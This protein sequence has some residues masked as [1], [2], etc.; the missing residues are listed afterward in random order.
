MAT[1]P[2]SKTR[3]STKLN[4]RAPKVRRSPIKVPKIE[5]S[6]V[7][8]EGAGPLGFARLTREGPTL[9]ERVSKTKTGLNFSTGKYPQIR[10]R[11]SSIFNIDELNIP[12]KFD[13]D[14]AHFKKKTSQYRAILMFGAVLQV[15]SGRHYVL[16]DRHPDY[17][18]D[19]VDDYARD[20]RLKSR[21]KANSVTQK[22]AKSAATSSQ[23]ILEFLEMMKNQ[24]DSFQEAIQD[25]LDQIF[26][27]GVLSPEDRK[28]LSRLRS[29]EGS[30]AEIYRHQRPKSDDL[31]RYEVD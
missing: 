22:H 1:K 28:F 19:V 12:E 13:I 2:K 9:I 21:T 27:K 4:N 3:S 16:L 25:T 7:E 6:S 5:E 30:D 24:N 15:R 17:D 31:D 20:L 10:M 26:S 11:A 23:K 8:D 29:K 14:F 18:A